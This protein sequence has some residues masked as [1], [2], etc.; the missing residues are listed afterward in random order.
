MIGHLHR[1]QAHL[2]DGV[3]IPTDMVKSGRRRFGERQHVMIAA[4]DA[5]HERDELPAA[6]REPEAKHFL[7]EAYGPIDVGSEHQHVRYA[8]RPNRGSGFPA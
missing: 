5:V 7:V 6:V 3:H 8:P 4:V 2:I 1:A